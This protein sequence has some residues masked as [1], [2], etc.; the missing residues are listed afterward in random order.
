MHSLQFSELF[1][2]SLVCNI[3]LIKRMEINEQSVNVN[4]ANKILLADTNVWP[5]I[6]CTVFHTVDVFFNYT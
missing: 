4:Y 1:S 5:L 3:K 2:A 6:L